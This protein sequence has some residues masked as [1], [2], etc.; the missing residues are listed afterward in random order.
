MSE[1][2]PNAHSQSTKEKMKLLPLSPGDKLRGKGIIKVMLFR[3][4]CFVNTQ[5][6]KSVVVSEHIM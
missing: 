5:C 3:K 4:D 1:S 2:S 6:D